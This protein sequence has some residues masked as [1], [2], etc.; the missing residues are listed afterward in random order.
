MLEFI[1]R[2]KLINVELFW[3]VL[4]AAIVCIYHSVAHSPGVG[5]KGVRRVLDS[6]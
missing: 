6:S 2:K 5:L 4:D 3:T 1:E